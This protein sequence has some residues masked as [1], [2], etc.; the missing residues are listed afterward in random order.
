MSTISPP[1]LPLSSWLLLLL[2]LLLLLVVVMETVTS[3]YRPVALVYFCSVYGTPGSWHGD[4]TSPALRVGVCWC[5]CRAAA[6]TSI[7][8][9]RDASGNTLTTNN[10][11]EATI[12]HIVATTTTATQ[13]SGCG[14][15]E[16]CGVDGFVW[17]WWFSETSPRPFVCCGLLEFRVI[18]LEKNNLVCPR[19][20]P[21]INRNKTHKDKRTRVCTTLERRFGF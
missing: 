3:R 15:L 5:C 1:P 18:C 12:G 9:R 4:M 8:R 16:S 17:F 21:R 19:E 13:I 10:V 7:L 14:V 11:K 20:N 6:A 2:L